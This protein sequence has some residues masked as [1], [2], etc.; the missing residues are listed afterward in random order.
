MKVSS[1][2]LLVTFVLLVT[3]LFASNILLKKEYDKLDKSDVYWT[4]A[5]ILEQPF[6][7]L[8]IEGGNLTHIAYE[9]SDKPS[10]RV[11]KMW[12]GFDKKTVK[13]SV[14]NDTLFIKFP[15]NVA[16][17]NDKRYMSWNTLVRIFSPELLSVNGYNTNI[18]LFKMHQKNIDINLSGRSKFEIESYSNSFDSLHII[19]RDSSEVVFEM[20]PDMKDIKSVAPHEEAAEMVRIPSQTK[21]PGTIKQSISN[22]TP[23]SW[24]TLYVKAVDASIQGVSLLDLGHAQINALHL[25]IS[26][27]SG[28]ILSG[29]SLGKFKK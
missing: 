24:E 26:D 25:N 16:D 21:Q 17:P 5:N 11:F 18:G 3:A 10:V 22:V 20:S 2:I 12:E 19:Q 27:T 7:H 23:S 8:V 29:G 13:A 15:M 14:R 28:I 4:Y 6:K 9:P 1:A